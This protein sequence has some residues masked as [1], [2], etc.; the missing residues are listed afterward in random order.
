MTKCHLDFTD[1]DSISWDP[2]DDVEMSNYHNN[3]VKLLDTVKENVD[4]EI[5][6]R[7]QVADDAAEKKQ[8]LRSPVYKCKFKTQMLK[9]ERP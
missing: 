2:F 4:R 5:Q 9:A 8:R 1:E 3:L 6:F 7:K